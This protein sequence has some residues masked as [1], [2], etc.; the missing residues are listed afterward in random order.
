MANTY[1]LIQAVTVGSGGAATID[2]TSI[3][4]TY[5]DLVVKIS[6]RDASTG[7]WN[8]LDFRISGISTS[9]YTAQTTYGTGTGGTGVGVETSQAEARRVYQQG[10]GTTANVFGNVEFYFPNYTLS[11]NKTVSVDYVSEN[12]SGVA[13]AGIAAIV[14]ANTTAITSLSFYARDASNFLQY[15]TA[16]LYGISNA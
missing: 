6:S 10:N 11:N 13:I 9:V 7:E 12:N 8:N 14:M 4:Q 5:T 2:F 1:S 16:Y 3:P 15:S